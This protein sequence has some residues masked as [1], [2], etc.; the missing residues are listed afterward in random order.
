MHFYDDFYPRAATTVLQ[1]PNASID[2]YRELQGRLGCRR[3]VIVQ[4]TTYGLDNQCQLD[5]AAVLRAGIPPGSADDP[6]RVIAVVDAQTPDEEIERLSSHGVRG[7]RFHMLP[8]G[9]VG[10]A[11]L[12]DVASRIESAGWH[13]QLQL[14]GNELAER[15]AELQR[16]PTPLV[17]DHVGRFMPPAQ[18][19]ARDE[20]FAALQRLLAGGRTWVKLSAPY[21]SSVVGP[22]DYLDVARM[23]RSLVD[24]FPERMLWAT[25]WPHPG[26]SNAPTEDELLALLNEWVPETGR[27]R[28]LI[29]NPAE[30]Y[31]FGR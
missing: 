4:P 31:G 28:V 18:D 27:Q 22:P 20:S 25:N 14:D 23:A 10:W 26:Q 17:I 21:E 3:T 12:A 2:Q 8:G 15:E 29:D 7:A 13:I 9:A 30:L 24:D 5:A 19:P 16:L 1:P 6:V 11:D